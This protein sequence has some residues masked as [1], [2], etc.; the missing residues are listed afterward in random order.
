MGAPL[1]KRK[2]FASQEE[3]SGACRAK[4]KTEKASKLSTKVKLTHK[5]VFTEMWLAADFHRPFVTITRQQIMEKCACSLGTVKS[6]FKALKLEGSI[7]PVYNHLGG[8]GNAVTFQL[9]ISGENRTPSDEHIQ[10]LTE[11]KGREATFRYLSG[12]FGPLK[13]VQMMDEMGLEPPE[14]RD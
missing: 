1:F 10:L 9:C 11:A 8:R 3:Y 2:G 12:K 4:K 5:H 7:K 6:A 13:A 14:P